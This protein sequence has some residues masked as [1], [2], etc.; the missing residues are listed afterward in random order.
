MLRGDSMRDMSDKM[1][2]PEDLAQVAGGC[3][4]VYRAR[5]AIK[6]RVRIKAEGYN[7]TLGVVRNRYEEPDG[8]YYDVGYLYG[9]SD[10]LIGKF[11]D[12]Y[13]VVAK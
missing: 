10:N 5:F 1:L 6:Q 8:W 12:R 13:L 2:S 4:G 3:G 9:E 7:G 11:H